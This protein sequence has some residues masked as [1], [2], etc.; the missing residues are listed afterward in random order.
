M[1]YGLYTNRNAHRD[2]LQN[3]LYKL[4]GSA[5]NVFIAVAFFTE[6]DVVDELLANGCHIRLI[7]RLGF[8]TNPDALQRVMK[9]PS[10]ETRF[11]TDRSFH[12]KLYI[13]GDREALVGSANLTKAAIR[14]NQEV[15][16]SISGS[17]DRFVELATLFSEYWQEASVLTDKH[18]KK[19]REHYSHYSK[20]GYDIS[21]L[22]DSVNRD[23]GNVVFH[24]IGREK[25]KISKENLFLENYRKTYQEG[26]TAFDNIRS[27]YESFQR[28]KVD[29]SRIPLRLEIDSFFSFVRDTFALGDAWQDTPIGWG[30]SQKALVEK[31]LN[32]WFEKSWPHLEDTI[33]NVNYPRLMSVFSSPNSVLASIDAELF[34]ALIAV[35]SFHDRLRFFP[36]GLAK[37]RET[38]FGTNDGKQIRESLSYLVFGQGDVTERMA[39][40]IFQPKYKLNEFGQANVQELIGW[41]NNEELPVIN[42]RTTKILRY[43][44]FD[45]RQL[46]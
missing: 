2:F 31:C 5:Q 11:F 35:H 44:G 32:A 37:L 1:V 7:V 13:F 36:G 28:R 41:C 9:T 19:Y 20:I 10:V 25:R 40:V 38:F 39:N 17:D 34:Q 14:T 24:N 4:A 43:F 16:V 30:E 27:I 15:V 6:T 8:P 33:V 22:D 29:E 12:P 18:L 45:V 26:V 42:G 3:A 23:I 21:S 46:S